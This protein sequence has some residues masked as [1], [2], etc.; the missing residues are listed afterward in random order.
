MIWQNGSVQLSPA[1]DMVELYKSCLKKQSSKAHRIWL[2]VYL[3]YSVGMMTFPIYGEIKH[4]PK[5]HPGILYMTWKKS[6]WTKQF[7]N[8]QGPHWKILEPSLPCRQTSPN[9]LNAICNT[10]ALVRRAIKWAVR[11]IP[12]GSCAPLAMFWIRV[13]AWHRLDRIPRFRIQVECTKFAH[14][15]S[16]PSKIDIPL[17]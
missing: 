2:V 9:C 10:Q 6:F 5:Y 8:P 7:E 11:I 17:V 12:F 15:Q 1:N 14:H 3:P 13:D 4:V 16:L